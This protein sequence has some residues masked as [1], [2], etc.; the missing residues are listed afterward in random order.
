[1]NR[2]YCIAALA[3]LVMFL[4]VACER[5]SNE[6]A[7]HLVRGTQLDRKGQHAEALGE[8]AQAADIRPKDIVAH[9]G[10]GVEYLWLGDINAARRE[11]ELLNKVS[12]RHAKKL[13]LQIQAQEQKQAEKQVKAERK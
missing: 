7:A 12:P 11:Y 13:L 8:F 2:I 9:Y 6:Y 1:M 3:C 10:M 4:V 5:G